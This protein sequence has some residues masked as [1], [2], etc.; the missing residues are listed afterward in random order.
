MSTTGLEQV[1]ENIKKLEKEIREQQDEI[2]RLEEYKKASI[3]VISE[4]AK[5]KDKQNA[6]ARS[7]EAMDALKKI[8][9]MNRAFE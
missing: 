5:E 1:R 9:D 4:L 2:Y 3:L 7:K 6:E 8:C